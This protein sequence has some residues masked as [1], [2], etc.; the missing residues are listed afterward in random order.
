MID[1][2]E[3][4]WLGPMQVVEDADDRSHLLEQ[5]AERPG[6]LVRR[7]AIFGLAEQ[8]G[9]RGSGPGLRRAAAEL[10]NRFDDGPVRDPLAVRKA[11]TADDRHTLE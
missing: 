3:E 5:P 7:P 4:G 2:V 6:D 8:R 11:A 9:D 10:E 1:E